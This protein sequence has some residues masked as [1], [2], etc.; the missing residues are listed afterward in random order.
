M[1]FQRINV[2]GASGTGKS[3][4]CKRL[5]E[6]TGYPHIQLDALFWKP[7]WEPTDKE[8]F[9][10]LLEKTLHQEC[11]ILDGNYQ[12]TS[13]VKWKNV[14][15]VI[16]LDYSFPLNIYRCIKRSVTRAITREEIW[17]G[18]GNRESFRRSFFSR[19]SIILWTLKTHH[20]VKR[21][22]HEVL[23]DK[24]YQHIE[25]IQLKSPKEAEQFL[26]ELSQGIQK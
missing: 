20:H 4:F 2:V 16:W 9:L 23:K 24:K 3:T 1:K 11:W 21:E 5:S 17:P 15:A 6:K 10:P 12:S 14:E 8:N 18:T 13:S 26:E 7:N 25:F 19:E 22:Y